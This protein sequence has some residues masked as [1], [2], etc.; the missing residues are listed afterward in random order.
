MKTKLPF[1]YCFLVS[2]SFLHC[3]D[4]SSDSTLPLLALLQ[5]GTS[6]QT[7]VCPPTSLPI[8]I[9]LADE[10]YGTPSST[11][12]G[13]NDPSRATN[14]ICGAGNF[15][16]SLD[17]YAMNLTGPGANLILG[18]SGADVQNV[19]GIDFIIYDNSFQILGSV[20]TYAIDPSVV[21]VSL[22][23]SA[24]CGFHPRYT[25]GVTSRISSWERFAG[26]Q[27]VTYNMTTN[28][29]SLSDLFSTNGA[30]ILLGG[31][32][33]FD[34]DDLDANDPNDVNCDAALVTNIQTNGFR[35]VKIR[36]A[37][38]VDDPENPGN[39]FPWPSGSFNGS[40]VDGVVARVIV[41]SP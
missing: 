37:S 25:G 40:D 20:D 13:F 35:Y 17:V 41:P 1:F 29:M 38:D 21:Q 22:D 7:L 26:L 28:P 32:D 39:K 16:G 34:L 23:G 4:S 12:S 14:G 30:G 24:W 31:G 6:S 27:P 33:G 11:V 10:V 36:S 2:F 19:T 15:S 3:Q 18:W 5:V 8:D 9:P